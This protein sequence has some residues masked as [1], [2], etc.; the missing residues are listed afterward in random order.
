[1]VTARLVLPKYGGRKG[2]EGENKDAPA[3]TGAFAKF[4]VEMA[5]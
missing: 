4:L 1:M 3:K 2:L 5:Q